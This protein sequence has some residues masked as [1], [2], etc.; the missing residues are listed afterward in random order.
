MKILI[1]VLSIMMV[2]CGESFDWKLDDRIYSTLEECSLQ[3][4]KDMIKENC[5]PVI[6]NKGMIKMESAL[7]KTDAIIGG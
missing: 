4:H 2:G 5:D 3:R 7:R 1:V 6:S